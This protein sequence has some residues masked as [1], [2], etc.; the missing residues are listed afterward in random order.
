MPYFPDIIGAE[1]ALGA[2]A[3]LGGG[4]QLLADAVDG[5]I[6]DLGEELLE[7]IVEQARLVG[8]H[9]ERRI[10]AH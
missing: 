6:R 10:V 1:I 2:E 3:R 4:D 5:R 9:G 8:E 7:V